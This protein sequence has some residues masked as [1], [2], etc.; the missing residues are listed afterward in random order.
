MP[1]ERLPGGNQPKLNVT[2]RCQTDLGISQTRTPNPVSAGGTLTYTLTV[3]NAGPSSATG[4]TVVDTLPAGVTFVS[5]TPTRSGGPNPL[6]WNLGT[7]NSGSSVNITVVVTVDTSTRGS[8][9]NVASVSNSVE[10][11]PNSANNSSNL[12]TTV[13]HP[14]VVSALALYQ[15]NR[16]TPV[17]AMDP[18]VE[19]AIRVTV[20]DVATLADLTTVKVTVF[21]DSDGD[22]DSGDV[23]ASGNTKTAAILTCT[24]G[25]TPSWSI[26]PGSGST[27]VM[28]GTQSTQ[29]SLSGTSGDFWFHFKP[30]KVATKAADWDIYAVATDK[31]TST[32]SR[33]DASNYAMNWYGEI[34]I[35]TNGVN[36]GT[37]ALGS[38]FGANPRSGIS[39]SYLSNGAYN[40][41]IRSGGT[42]TGGASSATLNG[43]GNP[44]AGEFSLKANHINDLNT[45]VGVSTAYA[46]LNTG[47][48]TDESGKLE[49]A[50]TLWLRLAQYGIKDTTYNGTL[51]YR[52]AP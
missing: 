21:Y 25:S 43:A 23:P 31:G 14:P 24:V 47:V 15:S 18:Q 42:W 45:A 36:W 29:P 19:Y 50:N 51:Y 22:N 28:R 9:T 33:Y 52:I 39:V 46:T 30:G 13:V 32:G 40:Q 1:A 11:D 37:V 2:Y 44:A 34:T 20:S 38:D 5:S 26:D 16:S 49:N 6:V 12:A 7:L 27:W 3:T 8:I 10:L 41:Q 48:Q 35:N 17:T 4:V